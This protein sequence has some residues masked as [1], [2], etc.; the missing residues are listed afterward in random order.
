MHLCNFH[1]FVCIIPHLIAAIEK[2]VHL[3]ANILRQQFKI[4]IKQKQ[5]PISDMERFHDVFVCTNN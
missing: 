4:R 2:Q 5:N 1:A 3:K